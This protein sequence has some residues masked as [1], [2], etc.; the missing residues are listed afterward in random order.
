MIRIGGAVL[1]LLALHACAS[2]EKSI[3]AEPGVA[4]FLHIGETA[5]IKGSGTRITFREVTQESR[6]PSNVTCVWEGDASIDVSLSPDQGPTESR[7]LSLSPLNKEARIGDLVIRFVGLA[8][9]PS[10]PGPIAPRR[11]VA[12]LLIR[13]L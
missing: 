10:A 13:S 9:Y 8:P 12:E 11:Y 2:V 1:G 4:F 3:V 5:V 6:C 7:V